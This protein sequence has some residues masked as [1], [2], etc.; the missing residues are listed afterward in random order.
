MENLDP[1]IRDRA[2]AIFKFGPPSSPAVEA[3]LRNQWQAL[4]LRADQC[5]SDKEIH[6]S[7]QKIAIFCHSRQMS[8]RRI[9][10]LQTIALSNLL[11]GESGDLKPEQLDPH[12][13]LLE[14]AKC[15]KESSSIEPE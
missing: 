4:P 13:P 2:M 15:C 14:M 9:S 7:L 3:L 12:L 11:S 5:C 1:A 6:T 10:K 8:C